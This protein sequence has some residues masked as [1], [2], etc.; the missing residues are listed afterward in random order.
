MMLISH[1]ADILNVVRALI[2]PIIFFMPFFVG[3]PDGYEF[4]SVILIYALIGKTNYILHLH[5]HHP[6]SRNRTLN[7]L[8]ELCMGSVTGM[9]ASNWRIQ[10]LYGHHRGVDHLFRGDLAWELEA[11]TPVR[12][13]SYCA[14]S[15]WPTFLGPYMEAYRKGV[16]RKETKPINYRWAFA[17]QSLIVLLVAA[18]MAWQPSL[19]IF[20][21]IPL[22]LLTYLISRY[23]DYLN[24][25][26]CDEKSEI[27][28]EHANNCLS[29]SF[30]RSTHNFGYHTAHHLRPGAHWTELPEIHR[31]IADKIPDRCNKSFNWE[32]LCLPYHL[33]LA[34]LG[35]M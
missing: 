14:R 8:L 23:V 30:N 33:Y 10:H 31:R 11:Y 6:F 24:H 35:K 7:R 2:A 18:L 34:R 21:A 3:L 13:I 22:Y 5:I 32:I 19:V 1:R 16:L 27:I 29:R 9:T 20:Y 15:M 17:E 12:V 25:Y 28:Y 4:L 26:G